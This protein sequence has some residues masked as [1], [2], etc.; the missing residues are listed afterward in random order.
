[1][2]DILQELAG[3]CDLLIIDTPAALAVSDPLPLMRSVDGVVLVA[4]MNSSSRQIISRLK[5]IIESANGRLLGVVATGTTAG[6]G[7]K[8]YY[9]K[10]YSNG[11][12]GGGSSHRL[13]RRKKQSE[14]GP[15]PPA[16]P[17][18]VSPEE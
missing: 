17:V 6:P 4:R 11:T 13:P 10:Y 8:H 2:Q 3:Q 1:M 7:Y 9:P 14:P 18:V 16:S 15:T 12:N 5:K